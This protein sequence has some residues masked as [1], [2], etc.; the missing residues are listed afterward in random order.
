MHSLPSWLRPTSLDSAFPSL[1]YLGET[2]HHALHLRSPSCPERNPNENAK[3]ATS[4]TYGNQAFYNFQS[5]LTPPLHSCLFN[6]FQ[7][8]LS[9]SF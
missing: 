1:G 3:N 9:Q 5:N 8:I 6:D 2:F 4:R 7:E